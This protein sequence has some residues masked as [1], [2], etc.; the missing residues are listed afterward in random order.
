MIEKFIDNDDG[1]LNWITANPTGYVV[2]C[3]RYPRAAYLVLHRATCWTISAS[4]G[5]WTHYYIKSVRWIGASWNPGLGERLEVNF[6]QT[7]SAILS[8]TIT[9]GIT[10]PQPTRKPVG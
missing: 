3:N 1:Y 8:H 10:T 9:S 6:G 5:P 4:K 2:N 7:H